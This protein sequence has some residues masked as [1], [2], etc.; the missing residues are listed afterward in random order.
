[1]RDTDPS[2]PYTLEHLRGGSSPAM[3][4]RTTSSMVSSGSSSRTT[5]A[6]QTL[7]DRRARIEPDDRGA[8]ALVHHDQHARRRPRTAAGRSARRPA[9][10]RAR[11]SSPGCARE[12]AGGRAAA[13]PAPIATPPTTSESQWAPTCMR[14]YAT[15]AASGAT[16]IARPCRTRVRRRWRSRR[17]SPSAPTGTTVSWD[18]RAGAGSSGTSSKTGRRPSKKLFTITSETTLATTIE[19]TPRIAARR[20]PTTSSVAAIAYQSRPLVGR[21]AQPAVRPIVHVPRAR[22]VDA[23]ARRAVEAAHPARHDPGAADGRRP[24][25]AGVVGRICRG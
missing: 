24:D 25:A 17:R 7:G 15:A 18:R 8:G 1:M 23:P 9:R 6:R 16:M 14:E 2:P 19:P 11:A 10:P 5:A 13:T 20:R 12:R 3:I 22:G 4:S 21:A